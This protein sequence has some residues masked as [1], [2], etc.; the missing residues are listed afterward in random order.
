MNKIE[1]SR[2]ILGKR[3]VFETGELAKQANGSILA[4]CGDT[5]VLITAVCDEV[6]RENID[7]FPLT[8]NYVEKTFAAGKIP[9]GFIKR[10][11]KFSEH[12][13]L[14]SRLID[15]AIRP[16][17]PEGFKNET[18][19]M[20]TVFSLENIN[21]PD[22]LA[23]NG[24]SLALSISNIPFGE[25]IGAVRV[26]LVNDKFII[27]PS[28]EEEQ[29]AAINLFV[30]GSDN[31]LVMVEGESK[32]A[33]ESQI[34]EALKLAHDS[35]RDFIKL[36]KELIAQINPQK[37]SFEPSKF[38]ED[39]KSKIRE[40]FLS[41][42]DKSIFIS[43]KLE[44]RSSLKSLKSLIQQ[45]YPDS[46]IAAIFEEI[47]DERVREFIV[48]DKKR[49]DG[50]NPENIRDI[51][52]QI[53]LFN[54]VHGS[55]LFTRGETQAFVTATLGTG[56]DEQFVDSL[57][58][59]AYKRFML[60]Y[61]FPPFSVGEVGALRAP[62]RRE[63]GHGNL[64]E[65]AINAVLPSAE[66]FPYTIR[67]VSEVL[68]SNGS[69]SMATVCG[70]TLALM[71]AG[72]PISSPVAGIAMGLIVE[73]DKYVV[74]SDILGDEDHL[75]DMDFKVAG[76]SKGVT[77]IQMDI[78]ISEL[79]FEIIEKAL[80]QAREGRLYILGK[81]AETI[82]SPKTELSQYAPRFATFSVNPDKIRDIIGPSGKNIKAIIEITGA[83]IDIEDNGYVK[84]FAANAEKL[85]Q[86]KNIILNIVKEYKEGDVC[87]GKVV[88]I[89]DFGAI[90]E[91][92]PNSSG[93]LHISEI[94][95][96]RTNKVT[97]IINIGDEV[98]VKI[99][100]VER[101]GKLKLSRKALL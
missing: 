11:G 26:I 34:I 4:R 47:V 54:R 27:N 81:M 6:G 64:A 93:L 18:Q 50:R 53:S 1:V 24:A 97:D 69:S 44:R 33:T 98:E 45:S 67:I 43:K 17:F 95:N 72:V 79:T 89:L 40:Q 25:P 63:I 99:I 73:G 62:G 36:Q 65:R 10:E 101:D 51:N 41:E 2:E 32:E 13:V 3:Y 5:A 39:L 96:Q 68:E 86:T 15:R 80:A 56:E 20:A 21:K 35:I 57:N 78:K 61:N 28:F 22:I 52:C 74:L 60:H 8:V 29:S 58:G 83:K 12:E 37:I 59:E 87:K 92:G 31:A 7:F 9:G 94:D 55:G 77:A 85:E 82:S 100:K 84:I 46:D 71:D 38:D 30:A 66:E 23:L 88:K 75:G 91:F 70:G 90:V 48:K 42:I 16:R 19:I 14:L 76:T 49:I